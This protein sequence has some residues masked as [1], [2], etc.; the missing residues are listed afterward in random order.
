MKPT[1]IICWTLLAIVAVAMPVMTELAKRVAASARQIEPAVDDFTESFT[2]RYTL[3]SVRMFPSQ[4]QAF[5]NQIESRNG[6]AGQRVLDAVL[7]GEIQSSDVA[8]QRLEAIDTPDAAALRAWYAQREETPQLELFRERHPWFADL[9]L[10]NDR[11][12]TDPLRQ[13]VMQRAARTIQFAAA[14]LIVGVIGFLVSIGLAIT[15]IVLIATGKLH[16][17]AGRTRGPAHYYIEGFTIY[18]FGFIGAS[19]AI[20]L[21]WPDAPMALRIV[22]GLLAMAAGLAW[23]LIRGA[24]RND[25]RHNVGMHTGRG[26]F[27]E[28]A[29]GIGGYLACMPLVGVALMISVLIMSLSGADASHPIKDEITKTSPWL[30]LLLAAVY[31][32]ITEELTFRGLMLAN[33]RARWGVIFSGLLSGLIFAAVHPQGWAAI[34]VLMTIGFVMA[35][36]RSWRGSIIAPI[37]A[38]ALNNGTVVTL[39]VLLMR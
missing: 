24:K 36:L 33:L 38:H 13:S 26:V 21:V 9:A 34:P 7:L 17:A 37:T 15:A 2:G 39:M 6:P 10:V 1:A 8:L 5:V 30:L 29:A 25:Y 20:E 14:A 22:P 27:T 11:P 4:K 28:I 32:P 3:G 18:F 16:Y 12:E 19:I 23:P 31:A 35:L